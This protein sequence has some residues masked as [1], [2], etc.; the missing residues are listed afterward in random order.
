MFR[1]LTFS[2][3]TSWVFL[4]SSVTVVAA[5]TLQIPGDYPTIQEAVNA[6][7]PGDTIVVQEGIYIE[8]I[9]VDKDCLE[10]RSAD[11]PDRTLIQAASPDN[12]VHVKADYVS[13]IGFTVRSADEKDEENWFAGVCLEGASQCMIASNIL[14]GN[15]HGTQLID[16]NHNLLIHNQIRDN[17]RGIVLSS[18]RNGNV[19]NLIRDN[20]I[21]NNQLEGIYLA[22]SS[23]IMIV[24]NIIRDNGGDG[25]R[26]GGR[27]GH[28]TIIKNTIR[29]NKG[30]SISIDS[31]SHDNTVYLNNF[32]GNHKID[33]AGYYSQFYSPSKIAY[34]RDGTKYVSFLGNYWSNYRGLSQP[35]FADID[36]DGIGDTPHSLIGGEDSYPLMKPFENYE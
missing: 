15:A 33:R 21:H 17:R 28:N 23:Q 26:I 35:I 14:S 18:R 24:R 9:R 27:E 4:L 11:G 20:V 19:D 36:N 2:L 34:L 6:A 8:N 12:V 32:I 3:L 10:I 1:N 22:W 13:I 30:R 5:D 16:S 29:N 31:E 25:I 7:S